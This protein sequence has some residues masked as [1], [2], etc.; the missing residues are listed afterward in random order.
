MIA[1]EYFFLCVLVMTVG[2]YYISYRYATEQYGE[3]ML[4]AL[5][6]HHTGRL[7][8][9]ASEDEHGNIELEIRIKRNE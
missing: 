6:L 5:T 3:G 8:Y 1:I 7:T 4:D 2:G 9:E